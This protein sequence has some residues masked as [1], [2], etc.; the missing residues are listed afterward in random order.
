M[1]LLVKSLGAKAESDGV[2]E[3]GYE[4]EKLLEQQQGFLL[5]YWKTCPVN[6]VF[7]LPCFV[8]I[9]NFQINPKLGPHCVSS[10]SIFVS[11]KN[12]VQWMW[13]GRWNEVDKLIRQQQNNNPL[14]IFVNRKNQDLSNSSLLFV[15]DNSYRCERIKF[16]KLT[17]HSRA[18][19]S[20]CAG[21]SV[22]QV[23]GKPSISLS[24]EEE[25]INQKVLAQLKQ[26]NL[27]Q[28][29][30]LQSLFYSPQNDLNANNSTSQC[31][32][33]KNELQIRAENEIKEVP[34]SFLDP[35][36]HQIMWNP[37]ILPSG[38]IIDLNTIYRHLDESLSSNS[39]RVFNDPFTGL[40]LSLSQLIRDDELRSNLE[41]FVYNYF[42][43][44]PKQQQQQQQQQQQEEEQQ[45]RQS[46]ETQRVILAPKN[47]HL[48]HPTHKR[49]RIS[50]EEQNV[51]NTTTISIKDDD[52]DDYT[53]DNS[54]SN[55][56]SSN[57]TKKPKVLIILDDEYS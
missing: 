7:E 34:E 47:T 46:I 1:N 55:S 33:T 45:P 54:N 11:G 35:I 44:L 23:I 37:Y 38:K 24:P 22:F 56:N 43:N 31:Y 14:S 15:K 25:Q 21:I 42:L 18:V 51:R 28:S 13:L 20:R 4:A 16:V 52:D 39:I 57:K 36:T 26:S 2:S 29:S 48:N 40:P 32:Y 5:S 17:I 50:E 30:K 9:E 53:S 41:K 3:D 8:K 49:K 10:F 19:N 12:K 6:L 27:D